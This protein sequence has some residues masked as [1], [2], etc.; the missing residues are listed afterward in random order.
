MKQIRF[1]QL[2]IAL[3]VANMTYLGS[4]SAQKKEPNNVEDWSKQPTSIKPVVGAT[5]P[6]DAIVLFANDNL[7]QWESLRQ[8]GA[9]AAWKVDGPQFTVEPGTGDIITKQ[10][11]GDCQLHIEWNI[12]ENEVQN[13]LNFGNSGIYFMGLYEVQIYSSY[14]DE[15]KI[16]YNGQAGS[17]YKQHAPLVNACLPAGTWQTYDIVF[18]APRFR[19]D[20]SVESPASFTVFQNGVLI[21]N[22]VTLIGPTSHGPHTEYK[23]H[24]DALPLLLQEHGS[25]VS[26]K[27]IWIRNL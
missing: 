12:P 19:C 11:F 6:S 25:K 22:H 3:V 10:S 2:L 9:P 16:Y 15:H 17:I 14:N 1:H 20:N 13:N 27:N 5:P 18:T 26:Y 4:L 24:E 21:Q 8:K 23:S 7:S